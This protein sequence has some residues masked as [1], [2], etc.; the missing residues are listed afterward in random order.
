MEYGICVPYYALGFVGEV[1]D[2]ESRLRLHRYFLHP[3]ISAE[4]LEAV[5][6]PREDFVEL[7]EL[8]FGEVG[9]V[10]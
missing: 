2:P 1:I 6:V 7:L 5:F 9:L 8:R 4:A 10:I 3:S